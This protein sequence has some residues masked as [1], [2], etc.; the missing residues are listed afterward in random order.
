MAVPYRG[1]RI[2][3]DSFVYQNYEKAWNPG[4][5]RWVVARRVYVGEIAAKDGKQAIPLLAL[6]Q[7]NLPE[8]AS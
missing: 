2:G 1:R 8:T 3:A 5:G 6:A 7:M 4:K